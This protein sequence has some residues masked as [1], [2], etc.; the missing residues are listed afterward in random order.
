M[1]PPALLCSSVAGHTLLEKLSAVVPF[2]SPLVQ[3]LPDQELVLLL[4]EQRTLALHHM[5]CPVLLCHSAA[6]HWLLLLLVL[7]L[8]AQRLHCFAAEVQALL[9]GMAGSR[10]V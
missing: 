7:L 4:P 8:E 9:A 5:C 2:L 6:D 1:M 3:A 10:C